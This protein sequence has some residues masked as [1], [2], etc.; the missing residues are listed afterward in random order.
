MSQ[1][2][3][4]KDAAREALEVGEKA[5]Q[6]KQPAKRKRAPPT[7]VFLEKRASQRTKDVVINYN[8]DQNDHLLRGLPRWVSPDGLIHCLNLEG[9][10][11]SKPVRMQAR[12]WKR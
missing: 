5:K 8:E 4:V 10:Q 11:C 7:P 9:V 12:E 3:G 1:A 6:N 2:L